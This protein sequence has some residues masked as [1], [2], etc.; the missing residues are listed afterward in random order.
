LLLGLLAYVWTANSSGLISSNDGSHLA[1]ARALAL[2]GETSID[3]DR[4][5]TLE[6]D[7][8]VR[9]GRSYSDRPPGTAFAA[10]P[11]VWLG[12]RLDPAMFERAMD[13][14]RSGR[15]V[16]PLPGAHPY[17][18][19]YVVRSGRGSTGPKLAML[20]GTTITI[21]IHAVLVG[22]F[23]IVIVDG[24]LRRLPGV[25]ANARLF[26]LA[27][28]GLGTAWGPYAS[29]LFSHGSAA[30]AVAGFLL[31]V[32]V[33]ADEQPIARGKIG[34]GGVAA[35]TGLAGAWA[36][37]CDYLL[38]LAIVPAAALSVA[39]R[40]WPAVLLGA[41][42]ISVATLAY[43]AAAFGSPFALG[44]DHQRNFEFARERSSTF[45]GDL[46]DGLWTLW[47]LGRSA[48]LLAQAPIVLLGLGA[49]VVVLLAS[50][51]EPRTQA[52]RAPLAALG[53]A[54][55]GFVPWILALAL[56]KTP[57]GG[58]TGDHRYLIPI[59]PFAAV[60]L[61]LAWARARPALRVLLAAVGLVSAVLVWRHFLGWHE[62]APFGRA[63]LASVV[64]V[65]ITT[66]ALA[67]VW[68]KARKHRGQPVSW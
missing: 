39:W 57:W 14:A 67:G 38:L 10:V 51:T 17:I 54:M 2:R 28:L 23:G 9:E 61:G 42:P 35:L 15:A 1:L 59:L 13:Q 47:G 16:E 3:P 6:V 63:R 11:A 44:Y 24:V 20:I 25:D 52:G 53:W 56:H 19:T 48:G 68:L 65:S 32:V 50:R 60:G 18:A 31:G 7:V 36:I 29:A 22:L 46:V 33:L 21:T 45:S 66:V 43:H 58:G 55:L 12:D 5:L 41:A 8:A 4:A 27:C 49:V 34:L 62:A 64:A 37:A 26:A 30:T 40:R